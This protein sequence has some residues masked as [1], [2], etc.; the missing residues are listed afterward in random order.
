MSHVDHLSKIPERFD[1]IASTEHAPYAIIGHKDKK[2]YG[3]QFHPEVYHTLNG[4]KFLDNFLSIS[5]FKK[6]WTMGSYKE[7]KIDQLK[8][9]IGDQKVICALSG[10][11]DEIR[12]GF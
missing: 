7:I 11:V 8:S 10:G 12:V 2:I 1:V 5:G 9:I 3:V 4:S 6:N